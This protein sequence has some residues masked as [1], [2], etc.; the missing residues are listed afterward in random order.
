MAWRGNYYYQ[1][2]RIGKRVTSRYVGAGL[3]GQ[4][5]AIDDQ[6]DQAERAER[7]ALLR[8]IAD[9]T[10]DAPEL[11]VFLAY[12][13][14]QVHAA[15]ESAGYHQHKRM[16]RRRMGTAE[17]TATHGPQPFADWAEATMDAMATKDPTPAALAEYH[18]LLR[19]QP[20]QAR[21]N[22][23]LALIVRRQIRTTNFADARIVEAVAHQAGELRRSL[24]VEGAT[25]LEKLLIDL[26]VLTW[27]DYHAHELRYTHRLKEGLSLD[28]MEAYERILS[29]KQKRYLS[30]IETLARVRRMLR[31]PA[32]QVNIG[33]TQLIG[34]GNAYLP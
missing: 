5:T 34:D 21:E 33:Q 11:R 6:R 8:Q 17:S 13:R 9:V 31:L 28:A 30:A 15:L 2:I 32:V 16:W 3:V 12:V 26:I 29:S 18:K 25:P 22:G 10:R 4:L 7:R 20:L 19:L 27:E 14:D 1:T 23:D 24:G